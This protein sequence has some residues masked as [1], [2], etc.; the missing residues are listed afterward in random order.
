MARN[1]LSGGERLDAYLREMA[2]N[3]DAPGMLEVGFM[4]DATE[5][6]GTSIPMIA[7]LNEFGGT[8]TIPARETTIHR[9]LNEA[10]GEFRKG[11]RFVKAGQSDFATTHTVPEYTVTIPPRP[12]F[13]SMIAKESPHWGDDLGRLLVANGYD[14]A[15]AFDQMGESM[16]GE[17]QQSIRDLRTP[18]NA[19]STIARKGSDDPLIDS[20]NLLRSVEHRVKR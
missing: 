16:R 2:A 8:V 3:L 14:T 17:L 12:F 4:E 7:A 20:S 11:G 18:A 9:S 10:T 6:D 15:R 13:R 5:P 1:I 19:P